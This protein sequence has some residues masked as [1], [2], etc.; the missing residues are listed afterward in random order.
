MGILNVT[1]DSFSDGGRYLEVDRAVERGVQMSREGADLIDVGGESTRP[2]AMTIPV[3]EELRRV[4]P[5]IRGLKASGC[6]TISVDTRHPEVAEA[7]LEAGA[8][9]VNDIQ[10]NR[11]DPRLWHVVREHRAGYVCMHMQGEPATMQCAPEYRNVASEVLDFLRERVVRLEEVGIDAERV[12][13][14]PGIGFGKTRDHNWTL[15][16]RIGD[17]ARL[18]RPVLLGVSRKSFLGPQAGDARAER[19]SGG[20]GCTAW[21]ATQGVRI[22]RTHDVEPTVRLLEV[23]ATLQAGVGDHG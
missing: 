15:L 4:L 22:F 17:L 3:E 20:L 8:V 18:G 23:M 13:I 10:S 14:D 16:R 21:A 12:V 11:T 6:R 7:A 2:G 19:I 1:P 9:I 5:V